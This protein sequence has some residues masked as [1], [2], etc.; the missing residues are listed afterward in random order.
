MEV[1]AG[2]LYFITATISFV[3]GFVVAIWMMII[4]LS[5]KGVDIKELLEKKELD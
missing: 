1:I 2:F 5:K 3:F 4:W